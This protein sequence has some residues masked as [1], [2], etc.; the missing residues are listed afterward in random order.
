MMVYHHPPTKPSM[1]QSSRRVSKSRNSSLKKMVLR[2]A[3]INF[4]VT[5][6][7]VCQRC[8]VWIERMRNQLS[9][10]SVPF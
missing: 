8:C 10:E 1:L 2:A 9:K 4:A 7:C 5:Q 3:G 6:K